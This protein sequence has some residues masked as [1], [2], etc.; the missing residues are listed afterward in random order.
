MQIPHSLEYTG[1]TSKGVFHYT[2][3][4]PSI[5]TLKKYGISCLGNEF[6]CDDPR[7]LLLIPNDVFI[8]Q[9]IPI[10]CDNN[11]LIINTERLLRTIEE[12]VA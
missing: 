11:A 5:E 3:N 1:R 12:K 4:P 9:G 2:C 7:E 6:G 10:D 8:D